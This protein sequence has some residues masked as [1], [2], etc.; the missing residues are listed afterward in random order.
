MV[1]LISRLN[2]TFTRKLKL[3]R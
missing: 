1:M 3:S 2:T